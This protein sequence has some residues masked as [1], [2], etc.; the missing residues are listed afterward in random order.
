MLGEYTGENYF[1]L[2]RNFLTVMLVPN[3]VVDRTFFTT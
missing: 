2:K 3:S 1:G